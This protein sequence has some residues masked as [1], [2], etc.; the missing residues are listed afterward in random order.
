MRTVAA[1]ACEHDLRV[2]GLGSCERKFEIPGPSPTSSIILMES[3]TIKGLATRLY[4]W[5]R[6]V[7]DLL[8]DS[9][10]SRRKSETRLARQPTLHLR[11]ATDDTDVHHE[12]EAVAESSVALIWR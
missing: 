12:R 4:S 9:R 1:R 10:L 11:D 6:R 3:A 2:I 7:M 5:T 8:A